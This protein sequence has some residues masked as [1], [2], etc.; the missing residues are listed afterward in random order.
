MISDAVDVPV[1]LE[2]LWFTGMMPRCLD[3]ISKRMFIAKCIH[4]LASCERWESMYVTQIHFSQFVFHD[5]NQIS[6]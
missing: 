6:M 2:T 5:L 1:R 3:E 4:A